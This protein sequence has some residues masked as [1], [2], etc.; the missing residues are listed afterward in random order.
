MTSWIHDEWS[1]SGCV[2]SRGTT[3]EWVKRSQSRNCS[4]NM[5]H[6]LKCRGKHPYTHQYDEQKSPKPK[7]WSLYFCYQ[8]RKKILENKNKS[9]NRRGRKK[10]DSRYYAECR[11]NEL[12]KLGE[13]LRHK[14]LFPGARLLISKSTGLDDLCWSK[15]V[16]EMP[17][18]KCL[19]SSISAGC[20]RMTLCAPC[21]LVL[22]SL[23]ITYKGKKKKKGH[24]GFTWLLLECKYPRTNCC[25]IKTTNSQYH[26]IHRV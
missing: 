16:H 17:A 18:A 5:C 7:L 20:P 15:G 14:G 23:W 11:E 1:S 3:V 9:Q 24:S 8:E 13:T 19:N 22:S 4:L 21:C 25:G 10:N 2:A 6:T 26:F 12:H